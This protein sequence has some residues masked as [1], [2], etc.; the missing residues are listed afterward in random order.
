MKKFSVVVLMTPSGATWINMSYA[1]LSLR[2]KRS[3]GTNLLAPPYL[4][5]RRSTLGKRKKAFGMRL[6]SKH[7]VSLPK[8]PRRVARRR[9]LSFY[10]QINSCRVPRVS[11]L[12]TDLM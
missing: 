12:K 11:D 4:D 3:I 8:L 10:H 5:F 7:S 6:F 2:L 1:S 9:E